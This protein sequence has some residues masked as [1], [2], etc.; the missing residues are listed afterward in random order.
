[1]EL[2]NVGITRKQLKGERYASQRKLRKCKYSVKSVKNRS[3]K[4]THKG[5]S[6]HI[7]VDIETV[8]ALLVKNVPLFF[9][10]VP[11]SKTS[12]SC[13]GYMMDIDDCTGLQLRSHANQYHD[14]QFIPLILP[15]QHHAKNSLFY[16]YIHTIYRCTHFSG[17]ELL[18]KIEALC[19]HTSAL[20][21]HLVLWD[22]SVISFMSGT[23][24]SLSALYIMANG[25]SWYNAHGYFQ[26]NYTQEKADWDKVRDMPMD[27]VVNHDDY[28]G[29]WE[30]Y[31]HRNKQQL[32]K[33]KVADVAKEIMYQ[34][35]VHPDKISKGLAD[36]Y[37]HIITTVSLLYTYTHRVLVKPLW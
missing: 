32:G 22:D 19:R 2:Q 13:I 21:T 14:G 16:V 24:I 33:M 1:M 23:K 4:I 35:R 5:G 10:D 34:M 29:V 28:Y 6:A 8:F 3:L 17:T 36:T 7:Q 37:V 15:P 26:S 18:Q 30:K 20:I 9:G 25:K 31:S 12:N 27:L 11:F